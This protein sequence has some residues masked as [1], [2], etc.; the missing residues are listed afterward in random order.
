MPEWVPQPEPEPEPERERVPQPEPEPE[1]ALEREWVPQPE[2]EREPER[3]PERAGAASADVHAAT[4]GGA[5]TG[6]MSRSGCGGLGSSS[7]VT[8]P[9][10]CSTRNRVASLSR[11]STR[12]ERPRFWTTSVKT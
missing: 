7:A 6:G 2:P 9:D 1:P 3:A 10:G 5:G 12:T 4:A 8:S 11:A